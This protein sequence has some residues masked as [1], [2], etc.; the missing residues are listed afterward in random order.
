MK[1]YIE[2]LLNAM[3]C[4]L[5]VECIGSIVYVFA[6]YNFVVSE[7]V[8]QGLLAGLVQHFIYN[9]SIAWVSWRYLLRCK[10]N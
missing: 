5:V 8:E 6:E 7:V 4:V 2:F 1:K 3:I 10:T 9:A